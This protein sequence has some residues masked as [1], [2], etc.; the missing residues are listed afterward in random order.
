VPFSWLRI[1]LPIAS[2]SL[3]FFVPQHRRRALDNMAMI[4]GD[5]LTSVKRRQ[6]IRAL[7][8][9]LGVMIAA[10]ID[11]LW[12]GPERSRLFVINDPE[13]ARVIEKFLKQGRGLIIVTA[14]FGGFALLP[15]YGL[16]FF[17]NRVAVVAARLHNPYMRE[18]IHRLHARMGY[19]V[20]YR[21][22]GPWRLVRY[23]QTGGILGMLPDLEMDKF[24]G[25]F[26]PF[27]G[28]N[29][30]TTTGPASLSLL[31]GCPIL[32]VFLI[33]I[34]EKGYSLEFGEPIEPRP[35]LDKKGKKEELYR[36]TQAWSDS[37]ERIILSHPEQWAWFRPRGITTPERLN[38]K[39]EHRRQRR[40]RQLRGSK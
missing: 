21:E 28:R 8:H 12:H 22:E 40:L 29:A 16:S 19:R 38:Y 5:R 20:F 14:H 2:Q 35:H 1:V 6:I 17:P 13:P 27:L 4:L 36:M 33:H 26:I 11:V 25:I 3:S 10:C 31:T 7:F 9:G 23:L 30:Y 37:V 18:L 34:P 32:P 24:P 15:S 39:R